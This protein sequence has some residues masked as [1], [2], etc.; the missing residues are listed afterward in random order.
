MI[1]PAGSSTVVGVK[2]IREDA[3]A[4][5]MKQIYRTASPETRTIYDLVGSEQDNWVIRWMLWH[6][7][8]DSVLSTPPFEK[9]GE[10]MEE[11]CS[12]DVAIKEEPSIKKPIHTSRGKKHDYFDPVR[13]R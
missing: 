9:A 2:G 12:L 4:E 8:Q 3:F 6:I 5:V 7:F 1:D 13:N 10:T 11:Q